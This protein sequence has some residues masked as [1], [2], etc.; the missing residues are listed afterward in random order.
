MF[1]LPYVGYWKKII[2]CQNYYDLRRKFL[3]PYFCHW[4]AIR[5][6]AVI[7]C[8]ILLVQLSNL[9]KFIYLAFKKRNSQVHV[10]TMSLIYM[11][12]IMWAFTYIYILFYLLS[13][14]H[15]YILYTYWLLFVKRRDLCVCLFLNIVALF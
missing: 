1:K 8:N 14:K 11:S 9:A 10:Y 15:I 3:K 13:W 5:K 2:V 7:L 12:V 6:Y 4:P